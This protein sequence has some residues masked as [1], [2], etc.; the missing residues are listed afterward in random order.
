M[1]ITIEEPKD[2]REGP[3]LIRA[4]RD[5]LTVEDIAARLVQARL[6]V[7][8]ARRAGVA[9][10][11][12]TFGD[13]LDVHWRRTLYIHDLVTLPEARGT[14][15][16][17]AL[18]DYATAVAKDEGHDCIRLCSGMARTD[19][20]RFYEAQGFQAASKQFVLTL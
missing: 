8:I 10:G 18:V 2:P 14:G 13:I 16:G 1:T 20:H 9:L 6:R 3:A 4:L 7:A 11:A 12:M 5:Q 19:A 15:I 17:A